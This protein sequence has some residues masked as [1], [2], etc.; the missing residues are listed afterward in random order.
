MSA[1]KTAIKAGIVGAAGTTGTLGGISASVAWPA[2]NISGYIVA[3]RVLGGGAAT[4]AKVAA[5]GGP[6]MAAGLAATGIGIGFAAI[7]LI[8]CKLLEE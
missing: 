6:A 8:V 2:S 4:S 3:A 1:A 5:V 7:V